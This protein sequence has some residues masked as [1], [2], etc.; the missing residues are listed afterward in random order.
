M[1]RLSLVLLAAAISLS[2]ALFAE[3]A[4]TLDFLVATAGHGVKTKVIHSSA[5][6][7]ITSDATSS[8]WDPLSSCVVASRSVDDATLQ[9]RR[10]VCTSKATPNHAAVAFQNVLFT[11]DAS[12][13]VRAW[14]VEEGALIWDVPPTPF[15]QE[16]SRECGQFQRILWL[17]RQVIKREMICLPCTM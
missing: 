17:Q 1:T 2:S 9:W 15:L 13:S 6:S 10:N 12:G 7:L 5:K 11:N 16:H 8:Q 14:T 3:D 4:G